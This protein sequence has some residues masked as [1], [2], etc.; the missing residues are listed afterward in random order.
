MLSFGAATYGQPVANT[1]QWS[2]GAMAITSMALLFDWIAFVPG[3]RLFTTGASA[4]HQGA[5][6]GSGVGRVA[7]GVGA[8]LFDLAALYAWR[9]AIRSLREKAPNPAS[10]A[11]RSRRQYAD[12]TNS[13]LG[14]AGHD[15]PSK[16]VVAFARPTR[17]D[18]RQ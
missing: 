6:V 16:T 1:R 17:I 2:L 13:S 9:V 10:R 15:P 8:I 12:R 5:P 18:K 3:P 7:F 4:S 11:T 14:E